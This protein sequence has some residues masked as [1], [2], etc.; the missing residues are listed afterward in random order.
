MDK[1]KK[2]HDNKIFTEARV[3]DYLINADKPE[4][5]NDEEYDIFRE[6]INENVKL[7]EEN[8]IYIKKSKVNLLF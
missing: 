3:N 1:T 7:N 4:I 5:K 2:M 8:P 6:R